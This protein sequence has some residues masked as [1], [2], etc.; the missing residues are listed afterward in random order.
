M[1][2]ASPPLRLPRLRRS[3]SNSTAL[4]GSVLVSQ[5]PRVKRQWSPW[6]LSRWVLRSTTGPCGLERGH[7]GQPGW[8]YREPSQP[9]EGE[10]GGEKN[11][12]DSARGQ[13]EKAEY[14]EGRWTV[15]WTCSLMAW[16]ETF[17][18]LEHSPKGKTASCFCLKYKSTFWINKKLESACG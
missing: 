9:E 4:T 17:T 10:H 7:S 15:Q 2:S 16:A 5:M 14:E 11:A 13:R 12:S 6:P 18:T 1:L 3:Y 8:W